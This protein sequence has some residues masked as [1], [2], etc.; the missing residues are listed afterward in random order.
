MTNEKVEKYKL[1]NILIERNMSYKQLQDKILQQ[2]PGYVLGFDR[3]SKIC[4]RR[5]TN[6]DLQLAIK[7]AKA[8]DVS[9]DDIVDEM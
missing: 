9:L 8:L 1:K 2:N 4:N 7:I 5:Q 3:I 6:F